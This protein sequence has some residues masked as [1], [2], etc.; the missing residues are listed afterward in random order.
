MFVPHFHFSKRCCRFVHNTPLVDERKSGSRNGHTN[1]GGNK[2]GDDGRHGDDD[3]LYDDLLC[4][5]VVDEKL[6][7]QTEKLEEAAG[8][9]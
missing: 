5:L 7:H 4:Q 6:N 2:V 8:A 3:E 9:S 1:G